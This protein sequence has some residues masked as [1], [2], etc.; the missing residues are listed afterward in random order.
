L[1]TA[2]GPLGGV[3]GEHLEVLGRPGVDDLQPVVQVLHQHVRRL[4]GQR[5]L[6]PL[7]VPGDGHLLAE[8][9]VDG[10]QQRDARG[11]E[12]AGGQRVVLGLG[13]QVGRDVRGTAVSSARIPISVGPAS[14][15]MPHRPCTSRLAAAT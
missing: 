4:A 9:D 2:P 8:L 3:G 12:Q 7:P 11:D 14:E 1:R 5:R 13:D 10:V 6:D 15:S